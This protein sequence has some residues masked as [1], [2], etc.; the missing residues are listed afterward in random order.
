MTQLDSLQAKK[1]ETQHSIKYICSES[2]TN[3]MLVQ[4]FFVTLFLSY[5]HKWDSKRETEFERKRILQARKTL[6]TQS[7][8]LNIFHNDNSVCWWIIWHLVCIIACFSL[9][10][11]SCFFFSISTSRFLSHFTLIHR[12]MFSVFYSVANVEQCIA[13]IWSD[14]QIHMP[15]IGFLRTHKYNYEWRD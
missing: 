13:D 7:S 12:Q 4:S 8:A 11:Y 6:C 14:T 5:A 10:Q 15:Q 1:N 2:A 9:H 3:K